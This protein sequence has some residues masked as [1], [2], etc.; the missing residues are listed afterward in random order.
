MNREELKKVMPHREPMLLLDE[1][2]LNEDGTITA[3]Y[4]V[5]GDEYFLQ[6]HFPGNPLVPGVI[7]C[8]IMAQSACIMF[9][10]KAG[11]KNITP[12]Y[13]G[14][15]KIQF[16]S[17]IKPGDTIRVDTKLIGSVHPMYKFHGKLSVDGKR[18]MNGDFS[19]VLVEEEKGD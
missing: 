19:V 14:L 4:H 17:M 8:E 3:Y 11:D 7:Q 10:D 2:N 15:D 5:K 13:S 12:V 16:R 6:G 9:A 18:C 1:A